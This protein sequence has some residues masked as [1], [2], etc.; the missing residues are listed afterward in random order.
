VGRYI[1][2][3]FFYGI[4][5]LLGVVV[6]VFF[7]FNVLPGDP[8]RMMLGQRADAA[9]VEAINRDLGRDR[10]MYQQFLIYLNDLSP[11]SLHHLTEKNHPLFNDH[12]KYGKTLNVFSPYGQMG[13]LLKWPYLRR[14]YQSGK[15]VSE[16]IAE[17]MPST[18]V[19]AS[20]SIVFAIIVGIFL[21]VVSAVFKHGWIDRCILVF[22][23]L[24]MAAPSFFAG[25]IIAWVF[26]Y[27]LHSFTG[28]DLTGSLYATDP[29]KGDV[30]ALKNVILPMLALGI[31]PLAVVVQL[32]RNSML[33]VLGLDY[34]RTAKAKGL[35]YG[36][37]L[38]RH[39]LKNALNPVI[40]AISGWFASMIAGAFFIEYIFGWH[41]IGSV[42]VAA[43]EKYDFP[44]VMGSV[45]VV[46]SFFALI[47][48]LV[49][50][51]YGFLDPR[52]RLS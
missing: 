18:L 2:H 46:A 43:L 10:P 44:V 23:S 30:L 28:L 34:I 4:L 38:V 33:D 7:L 21:G 31:R 37:I 42:T 40:T 8:A 52:I 24:G 47:N 45:L 9:S 25:I 3:R 39:A 35:N 26:G 22:S 29:F 49:D 48:I 1:L 32:T 50:I 15:K 27:L 36:K 6:V 14:S 41:G 19:L 5:V 16:I 51:L 11:V 12:E 20:F 13:L 17:T